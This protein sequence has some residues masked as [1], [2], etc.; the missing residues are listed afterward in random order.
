[1]FPPHTKPKPAFPCAE[2]RYPRIKH[3]VSSTILQSPLIPKVTAMDL[4]LSLI[5]LRMI[6]IL[7]IF[8]S[9]WNNYI[10]RDI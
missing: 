2:T 8:V 1:M 5:F 7:V 10:R 6:S 3:L 9:K 4:S